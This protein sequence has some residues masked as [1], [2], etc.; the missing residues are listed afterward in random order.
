M[1]VV[2]WFDVNN[3]EHLRA[4]SHVTKK[5]SWPEAFIPSDLEFPPGWNIA[6][7]AKLASAYMEEKLNKGIS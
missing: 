1:D 7:A 6:I 3:I 2:E 5:G 4:F